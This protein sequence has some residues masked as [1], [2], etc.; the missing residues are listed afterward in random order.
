MLMRRPIKD[1]I[2]EGCIHTMKENVDWLFPAICYRLWYSIS[3]YL[4]ET[5]NTTSHILNQCV[6]DIINQN[7][8]ELQ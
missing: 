3:D 6:R 5:T 8:Y 2:Q 4:V 1:K 7:V